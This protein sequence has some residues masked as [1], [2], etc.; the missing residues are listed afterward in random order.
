MAGVRRGHVHDIDIRIVD[1]SLIA[2]VPV[3]SAE[4]VPEGVRRSLR[5]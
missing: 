5:P 1:Q 2:R 4:L 3:R